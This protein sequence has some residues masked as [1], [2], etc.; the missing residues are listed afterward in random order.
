MY[1]RTSKPWTAL[2]CQWTQSNG[3]SGYQWATAVTCVESENWK[4]T[5]AAVTCAV[6]ETET[7]VQIEVQGIGI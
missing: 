3:L 6:Q 1:L 2:V 4:E 7:V 5:V